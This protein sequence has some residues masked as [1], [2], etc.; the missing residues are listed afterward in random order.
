MPVVE[1]TVISERKSQE[2][3]NGEGQSTRIWLRTLSDRS[4]RTSLSEEN[5]STYLNVLESG[6]NYK[7]D[8]AV[9]TARGRA[10]PAYV[11]RE[12]R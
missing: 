6:Q 3:K 8:E 4:S 1:S 9:G 7:P 12:V 10:T 2:V 5:A 11:H